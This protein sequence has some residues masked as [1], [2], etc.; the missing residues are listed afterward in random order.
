MPGDPPMRKDGRCRQ[1]R[2][3][4]P[5]VAVKNL[6]PFCRTDCARKWWAAETAARAEQ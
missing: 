1:C 2:K 6:D 5:P 3:P 4:L